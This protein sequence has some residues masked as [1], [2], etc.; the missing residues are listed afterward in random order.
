VPVLVSITLSETTA[1]PFS[2]NS[3]VGLLGHF[4]PLH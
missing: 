2:G 1:M 4:I 3:S